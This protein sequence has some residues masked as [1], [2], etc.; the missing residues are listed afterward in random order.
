MLNVLVMFKG[1]N[2][3]D[4][5]RCF[6]DNESCLRYLDSHKWKYGY[7][8]KQCGCEQYIKGKTGFHRRCQQCGYDESVT[9]NTLF[10][11]IRFPLLKAFYMLFRITTKKKGMSTVEL[12]G[13][14]GVQQKTAWLF[15]RKV[16]L[17]MRKAAELQGNVDVDEFIVGSRQKGH[18]GRKIDKKKAALIA[19][20]LLPKGKVGNVYL[21]SIEN[22]KADTLKY[23]LRQGVSTKAKIRTDDYQPYQTLSKDMDI[24]QTNSLKG[25]NFKEL[26]IQI[27]LFKSW[28][29]G[30]HHKCSND[31]FFAYCNEYSFRFNHRNCRNKIFTLLIN[32]MLHLN[33]HPYPILK[34][35]SAYST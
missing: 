2:A 19:V 7:L 35:L 4:F 27:M 11:D 24:T 13:E 34:T 28:M 9:A 12:A 25:R 15:K 6:P 1:I 20:E 8:C 3:I 5:A 18:Y 17:A 32:K 21:N 23:T 26:H 14:V 10:H 30:I 33:P 31:H 16:Q 22:F 29:R